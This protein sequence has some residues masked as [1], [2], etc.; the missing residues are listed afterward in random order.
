[1]ISHH[2]AMSSRH[3][4]CGSK[5][6]DEWW[7]VFGE[8]LTNEKLSDLSPTRPPS[9]I[10]TIATI[11]HSTSRIWTCAE[12][13]FTLCRMD[14]C[15]CFN[16]YTRASVWRVR[17]HMPL[18]KF[19]IIVLS[20]LKH[21]HA[22]F[23]LTR[24]QDLDTI[25]WQ[26]VQWRIFVTHV[27]NNNWHKL[28]KKLLLVHLE[29]ATGKTARICCWYA[30]YLLPKVNALPSLVIISIMKVEIYTFHM[31]WIIEDSHGESVPYLV[32]CP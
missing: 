23:S 27:Y 8:W 31:T 11:R 7:M 15:S 28:R 6:D 14:L 12:H 2:P 19:I 17:F 5:D 24:F 22:M 30:L 1:M 29:T 3:R 25:F 13:Y 32:R 18:V 16:L 21:T 9:N 26:C 10:L 4:N 20:S